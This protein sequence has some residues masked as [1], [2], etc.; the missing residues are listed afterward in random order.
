LITGEA[1]DFDG[2]FKAPPTPE[3]PYKLEIVFDLDNEGP[4][5]VDAVVESNVSYSLVYFF[6]T[7]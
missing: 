3:I 2:F 4:T 5:D 7:I 1:V 6:T